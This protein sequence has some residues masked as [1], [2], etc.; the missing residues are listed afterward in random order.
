L[1]VLIVG[2]KSKWLMERSTQRALTRDGHVTRV[3]DDRGKGRLF[4]AG[5][6][7]KRALS[8]V[9]KFKPDF[10]LL[11][12]CTG[13]DVE[14]VAEMIAGKPNAMWYQDAPLYRYINRPDIAHLA[15]VGR[16]V[17]NFFVS[18]FVNEWK[19][20][21]LKAKFLPSAADRQLGP[22]K[23]SKRF[24]SD[25]AFIGSGFD[26][27]RATF[28]AKVGKRFDLKVWGEGWSEWRKEVNWTGRPVRGHDFAG[29]CSSAKIVLG[30]TPPS[31][32][33]ATNYTSER[34]WMV[35]QAGGL[36]LGQATDGMTRLLRDGD[37]CASYKDLEQCLER[38]AYYLANPATRERVR[39]QGQHFVDEH[40]TYD[41]RIH[42][43]LAGEEFV[44]PLS[45]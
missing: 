2:S 40:H 11:G 35:I 30:I 15:A 23:P 9:R 16:L 31:A 8:A 5:M 36:Y 18:G 6:T 44:N 3:F 42:N 43:I 1:R 32:R 41:Q 29:V 33:G 10:V 20:L 4:G 38:C 37:H 45:L 39:V 26:K 13:L 22:V 21:G 27:S 24:S 19:G 25:V 17:D 7:Q 34:T 28:L 14:T 12:K